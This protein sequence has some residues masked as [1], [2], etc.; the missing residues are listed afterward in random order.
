MSK[1]AQCLSI[2]MVSFLFNEVY[3]KPMVIAHRGAKKIW[4][5]NTIYAFKQAKNAGAE[6]LELDVQVSKDQVPVVYHARN[7][8]KWTNGN[9]K[10]S[11]LTVSEIKALNAA[12]KFE[13]NNE[14]PFR[15]MNLK[16]PTLQEVLEEFPDDTMIVDMKSLPEEVLVNA[17]IKTISDTD[18]SRL[19]FYSTN[20]KHLQL[21][22]EKKPEAITFESRDETRARLLNHENSNQ[23]IDEGK[24]SW[25]GFELARKMT[26]LEKFALGS[27]QTDLWFK[28]WDRGAVKCTKKMTQGAKVVLF[29]I[30]TREQYKQAIKLKV[31]AVFTDDP[32]AILSQ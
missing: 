1:V 29:G 13:K 25:V 20:A 8:S 5:E 23:C 19:V 14:F 28:L 9:G 18:W 24:E 16:I 27:S 26:V 12:Y 6:A 4:P 21:L 3:A 31:D 32:S 11:D 15:S 7:V 2:V 17:L 30:N 10:I 22:K